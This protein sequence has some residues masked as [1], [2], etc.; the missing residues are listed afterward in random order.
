MAKKPFFSIKKSSRY[1][2][3]H[4]I[5]LI[6]FKKIFFIYFF[7]EKKKNLNFILFFKCPIFAIV[8]GFFFLKTF[9]SGPWFF[10]MELFFLV[11]VKF[12]D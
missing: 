2:S 6:L 11:V 9:F 12:R 1:F 8:G 4:K 5:L 3:N 7:C 10:S